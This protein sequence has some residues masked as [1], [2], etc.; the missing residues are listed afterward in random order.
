MP[1]D[2]ATA[3][4]SWHDFFVAAAGASAV[5]LGLVFIGLTIHLE[6]KK[7]R[8][9]LV[10]MAV[11]SATTL[12]YPVI[13]SLVLLMPPAQPWLP[14]GALAVV[15]VFAAISA[16]APIVQADLR[17][18]WFT[19]RKPADWVRYLVPAV[20][21]LVLVAAA[22]LMLIEPAGA[23][24]A[25]AIV[26]VLYLVVGTQNARNLLLAGRFEIGLA[27][28]VTREHDADANDGT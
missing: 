9:A 5:L 8:P 20:A 18:L 12:F 2:I 13:I 26:I 22:F 6:R 16:S 10:P 1:T 27:W 3:L 21:A 7:D 24:Y 23:I 15:A 4:S 14:T 11:G 28:S 25:T 17:T 19:T